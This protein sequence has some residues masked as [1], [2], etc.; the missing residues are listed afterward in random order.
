MSSCNWGLL[1]WS[2][3]HC[4]FYFCFSSQSTIFLSILHSL[5]KVDFSFLM[6]NSVYEE[7]IIIAELCA[8]R[9][10]RCAQCT[11]HINIGNNQG[12]FK[13]PFDL[14][15][16]FFEELLTTS[17]IV[18]AGLVN[19]LAVHACAVFARATVYF[20]LSNAYKLTSLT[21]DE[22]LERALG[23]YTNSPLRVTQYKEI[24]LC[25]KLASVRAHARAAQLWIIVQLWSIFK[26]I[27][28]A[29]ASSFTHHLILKTI[30]T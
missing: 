1:L 18:F 3:V 12:F 27:C 5:H 8:R 19:R 23:R 9:R 22:L 28:K 6:L 10:G 15:K 20:F 25:I 16:E 21:R 7:T 26:E 11:P 4:E 24:L 2:H 17:E 13:E 30:R 29:H 14:L